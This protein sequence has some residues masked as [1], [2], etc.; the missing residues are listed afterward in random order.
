MGLRNLSRLVCVCA[1]ILLSTTRVHADLLGL[2]ALASNPD[3][4]SSTRS[5]HFYV[6]FNAT[7]GQLTVSGDTSIYTAPDTTEYI[8]AGNNVTFSPGTFN[9]SCIIGTNGTLVSGTM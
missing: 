5:N 2:G 4:V 3:L 1:T 6:V 8:V 7:T 9:L